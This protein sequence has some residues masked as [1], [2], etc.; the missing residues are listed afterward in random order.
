MNESALE[1]FSDSGAGSPWFTQFDV[2]TLQDVSAKRKRRVKSAIL[3]SGKLPRRKH[4]LA[5]KA[6]LDLAKE[7]VGKYR[8]IIRRRQARIAR[9]SSIAA[10]NTPSRRGRPR[11]I[12][13]SPT[14]TTVISQKERGLGK[15]KKTLATPKSSLPMSP[16]TAP[17]KNVPV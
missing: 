4:I 3:Q 15:T 6:E 13:V 14:P 16:A 11:K 5:Q 10:T 9:K 8:E 12:T 1:E 7:S 2:L 17:L